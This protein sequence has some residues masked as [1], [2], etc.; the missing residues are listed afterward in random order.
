MKKL[1]TLLLFL[2]VATSYGQQ[3]RPDVSLLFGLNQ[4]VVLHGF[5]FEANIWMKRFVID[6]SHGFGLKFRDNLVTTEARDQH[7]SF[8]VSHS[9]GIGFGYRF[10]DAFNLRLEPK[11]HVWEMYYDDNFRSEAEKIKTY[12]TYTLGVGAY[13][14]WMPFRKNDGAVRELTIAPSVRWWPNVG[15]SLHGNQYEYYNTHTGKE[16]I[17]K[18]NNI[19]VANTAW[20][21]NVSVGWT[22]SGSRANK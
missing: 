9:L 13:Y 18:A 1:F 14:R 2:A 4:P 19:G 22:L 5:N 21:A 10:T 7:L 17:H 3:K 20:F 16:E 8:N 12:N 15:S 11:I 6:Y